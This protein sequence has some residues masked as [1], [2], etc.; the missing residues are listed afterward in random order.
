MLGGKTSI[1]EAQASILEEWLR[2]LAKQQLLLGKTEA[3]EA[4]FS[5]WLA[6]FSQTNNAQAQS[7]LQRLAAIH[8]R[9]LGLQ[10]HPASA[11]LRQILCLD[12]ALHTLLDA[13]EPQSQAQLHD[14]LLIAGDAH[15]LG[16]TEKLE[17]TWCLKTRDFTPIVQINADTVLAF[18]LLPLATPVLDACLGRMMKLLGMKSAKRA[19]LDIS[20]AHQLNPRFFDTIKA[21]LETE[22]MA[23]I[24]LTLTGIED[25][26]NFLRQLGTKAGANPRLHLAVDLSEV[27][28]ASQIASD[29]LIG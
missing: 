10:N 18:L 20:N 15:F 28:L 12:E 11:G 16:S 7:D 27:L 23:G 5:A 1:S 26:N 25:P 19:I 24:E 8:F 29:G 4:E 14:L 2:R 9:N 13:I 3:V 6:L 17:Q 21:L 22:E